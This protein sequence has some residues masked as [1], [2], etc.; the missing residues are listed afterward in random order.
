MENKGMAATLIM[1][2]VVSF[3]WLYVNGGALVQ[4]K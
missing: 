3:G 2:N 4:Q 1:I